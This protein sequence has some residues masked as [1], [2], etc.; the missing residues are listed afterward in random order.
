[1]IV[2]PL[3]LLAAVPDAGTSGYVPSMP[4]DAQCTP[5]PAARAPF[6]FGPGELLEYDLDAMGAKAGR[7]TMAVKAV[8]DS[9]LPVEVSVETNTFFSKVRRVKGLGTSF[10][11]PK[12]LHPARYLEDAMENEVHRVAD[13][14]FAKAKAAHLVST[15]NERTGEADLPYATD[16]LDV[17]GAIFLMRQVPMKEGMTMCFDIYGIRRMWRVWGTVQPREHVSLP[18]GEFEAWHLSGQAARLDIPQARR[19]VH[20]WISDDP[21][22]LPLAALGSIDIGTIRA[23]LTGFTRPGEKKAEAE[24]KAN[25]K[26]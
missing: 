16:G 22:H 1:V 5:L 19:E 23:T 2:L 14:S 12:T 26:W 20:V 11:N 9:K 18:V 3:L 13:V 4:S 25:I 21:R 10:L 6:A 8:K 15:V 24:N 17:A 7:M